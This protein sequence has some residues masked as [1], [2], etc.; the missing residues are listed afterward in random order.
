MTR[1]MTVSRAQP[2]GLRSRRLRRGWRSSLPSQ[3][4]IRGI[5]LP[6]S[7]KAATRAHMAS[8]PWPNRTGS[9]CVSSSGWTLEVMATPRV[10]SVAGEKERTPSR[11]SLLVRA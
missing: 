1:R 11:V 3:R 5:L 4:R 9:R 10:K 8:C 6:P 2:E 7:V